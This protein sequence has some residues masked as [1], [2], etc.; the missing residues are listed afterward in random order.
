M[1]LLGLLVGW[2]LELTMKSFGY[3]LFA[4]IAVFGVF[5]GCTVDRGV[6]CCL[7]GELEACTCA[8]GKEGSRLCV[9]GIFEDCVCEADDTYVD[10]GREDT[11]SDIEDANSDRVANEDSGDTTAIIDSGQ[12]DDVTDAD[13]SL[14]AEMSSDADESDAVSTE[15]GVDSDMNEN[16]TD[17]AQ[18]SGEQDSGKDAATDAGKDAGTETTVYGQCEQGECSGD[19]ECTTVTNGTGTYCS[20]ECEETEDCPEPTSGTAER[21]CSTVDGMCRL[22]C[23]SG[24]C[25][26]GMECFEGD[27]RST[28]VWE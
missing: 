3:V 28:C 21:R 9:D 26:D 12:M 1:N 19:Q 20:I 2:S 10:V 5:A 8:D 16:G 11:G 17:S 7:D 15:T 25:P 23:A 13:E 27:N 4:L 22:N 18:D 6:E 24:D 14:D